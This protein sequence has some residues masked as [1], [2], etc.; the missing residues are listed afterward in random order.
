[1]KPKIACPCCG[2]EKQH[3]YTVPKHPE[4]KAG[5]IEIH[6]VKF[7]GITITRLV[8]CE[9]CGNVYDSVVAK[10]FVGGSHK[11]KSKGGADD[12]LKS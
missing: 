7:E 5:S 11:K 10:K 2:S 4:L 9:D 6:A 8:S 1:M 12:W 3:V